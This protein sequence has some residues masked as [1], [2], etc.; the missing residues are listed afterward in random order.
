MLQPHS[1]LWHYLWVAPSV[2]LL[3]LAGRMRWSCL[4]QKFPVFFTLAIVSAMEQLTLYVCDL[5]PSVEAKTWWRVFW[6]G[7]LVESILKFALVGEIFARVFNAYSSIARLGRLV[8][9]GVGVA[10]VL[11]AAFAAAWA[12]QDSLFEIVNGAHLLEQ[13]IYLV[14]AGLLIVIF[15]LSSYFSLFLDR[16]LFGIALGMSFSALVH[17]ATWAVAANAGLPPPKRVI[18]DFVNMA[19]YHVCVLTW[20]YYLLVPREVTTK[21]PVLLPENNLDVWNRE[22]ER[23]VHP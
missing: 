21:S 18:L 16:P 2:L 23:L 12:P 14:E 17:F 10:L 19:T 9:S 7:L 1:L 20:F 5:V 15:S 11:T 22:L 4:H 13:T 3:V 8:I 6:A